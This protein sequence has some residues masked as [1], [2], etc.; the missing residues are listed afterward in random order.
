MADLYAPQTQFIGNQGSQ[1]P[2][3][4]A[5]ITGDVE[6]DRYLQS[7][8]E[9]EREAALQ[10]LTAPPTGDE[11]NRKVQQGY[12]P[13][14]DDFDAIESY[15]KN[16]EVNIAEGIGAGVE[17]VMG[18]LSRAVGAIADH[19]LDALS[20]SPAN[21]VEAFAQG[22]RNFYGMAAQSAD[23]TSTLFRF[24]NFLNGT[25]TKEERYNQYMEALAFNRES[26]AIMKGEKTLIMDK[27]LIT[28][29]VVQ[30]A[31]YIADPTLFIPFGNVASAGMRA[32][33]MGEKFMLASAKAAAIKNGLIG[34]T[35]KWG[36]GAPVEFLG[37]A[38]RNTIDY[39]IERGASAIA[40]TTGMA[41][42]EIAR[43]AKLSG[44]PLSAAS[45]AGHSIPYVGA[46][47]ETRVV[48]GAAGGFGEAISAVGETML[49][50]RQFGR[51][52]NSWA[53]EALENTPNL[54]G[55]A[56]GLLRVLDAVDPMFT[57]GAA[58][59]TGATHGALIGGT[60]GYLSG[61][62]EG[63]AHGLG[64]GIA[65]GAVGGTAGKVVADVTNGTLYER[66]AIQR[67]M[68]I[69]GLK[70]IDPDKAMA[71][72]ALVATAEKSG[73]RSYIA[74]ID[75]IIAGVDKVAPNSKFIIRSTADHVKWLQGEG[76]D[77][78]TG[79]L[80]ESHVKFKELGADRRVRGRA[81]G[82]LAQVGDQFAGKPD[83]FI[84]HLQTLPQDHSL[85]KAFFRLSGEQKQ[86]MLEAIKNHGDTEFLRNNGIEYAD[87]VD[88][89]NF[90][91]WLERNNEYF[92]PSNP[93]NNVAEI[94]KQ[95]ADI[96]KLN[97]SQAEKSKLID[98]LDARSK[99]IAEV[100]KEYQDWVGKADPKTQA[101][102]DAHQ[103]AIWKNRANRPVA[104]A[105]DP[106]KA[107]IKGK[108]LSEYYGD[109]NYAEMST[110]R[111]NDLFSVGDVAGARKLLGTFLKDNTLKDGTL[112]D[113]GRMLR[114]KLAAEG[115]FDKDGNL[116]PRR[117][118]A[119][120]DQPTRAMYLNS[121]GF[122][123][124]RDATGAIEVHIS[125]DNLSKDGMAHELFH[126]IFKESV[127]RPD[128]IDR[129]SKDL[130]GTFDK[131]GKLIKA[132]S[133]NRKELREFFRRYIDMTNDKSEDFVAEIA[134]LE[135]A[136]KEFETGSEAKTISPEA[137][138]T[139]HQ[140][141]EEFGA[142]YF[143]NWLRAQSPDFLFRGGK[144]EGVRGIMDSAK[145]GWLDF[146]E[147][148]FQSKDPRF[149]FGELAEGEIDGG[150]KTRDGKRIR[151]SSLDYFN[152]DFIRAT[153]DTNK[154]NFDINKLSAEG[155]A[156]Y[157]NSNGIRNTHR[158]DT[159]G[160]AVRLS[161]RE[162]AK[163]N[164][165]AGK[166]IYKI[167]KGINPNRAVDG[168]GN[169]I[170]RLN[171]AELDAIVKSGHANRAWANK[172]KMAYE[173]LDGKQS[174]VVE[175]GYFGKTEQI[176]DASYPRLYG[177]DV[178][179]KHRKAILLD[180]EMKIGQNGT[181]HALFHTLDKAVIEAR[182]DNLWKD[183]AVQDLWQGNRGSMEQDFF[184]Y[185]EN[186][187]KPDHDTSKIP[188]AEL[189]RDG[190]GGQ[191]RDV[192]HQMLGMAKGEGDTY[193]NKPIA[194][195][196]LGIRHSVTTFNNDGVSSFR[197][198]GMERYNYNHNNAFKLLS[199]NWKPS[200]MKSERT[201][202]GEIITHATGYKFIKNADGSV[203]AFTSAGL[204]IG[205]FDNIEQAAK[206]GEK[207][208]N[209]IYDNMRD[210]VAK[211]MEYQEKQAIRFKP[212]TKEQRL[213]A[214]ELGDVFALDEMKDFVGNRTLLRQTRDEH[215]YQRALESIND[216]EQL[217]ALA[218]KVAE[219]NGLVREEYNRQMREL[220]LQEQ[221]YEKGKD[222][223]LN[224]HNGKVA[225]LKKKYNVYD[226]F[227]DWRDANGHKDVPE[228][229]IDS[230]GKYAN[231]PEWKAS[232]R[233]KLSALYFDEQSSKMFKLEADPEHKA[234]MGEYA[235]WL[236]FNDTEARR[237][238]DVEDK[239]AD[240]KRKNHEAMHDPI[241]A[242][243][244]S[245][246]FEN[247][248]R[249]E[250]ADMLA[251][252]VE[253][254][255][256]QQD[257]SGLLEAMF[258][259]EYDDKI[260]TGKPFVAVT[261]HGTGNVE[262]MLSR[263]F[264]ADKLG[265]HYNIPSSRMGS[266]SAGSQGTSKAY[267][268]V[269]ATADRSPAG[270][271]QRLTGILNEEGYV[272]VNTEQ[273]KTARNFIDLYRGYL[274]DKGHPPSL[275]EAF[276]KAFLHTV[277]KDAVHLE[278]ESVPKEIRNA[279]MK[280]EQMDDK[281]L[282]TGVPKTEMQLRK[283]I[284]MDNPY[285]VVDPRSYDEHFI[286]PHMKRAME[287]G[288]DGIIFKRFADGGERDNVYVVFKDFMADNIKVI[289][290]SF[291]D[292]SVPRGKDDAGRVLKGGRELGLRF[293]PV[294]WTKDLYNDNGGFAKA[295]KEGRI[296][297]GKVEDLSDQTAVT[298]NPDN[299]LVGVIS[300][301][302]KEIFKGQG[303]V[304]YS[305]AN[306]ANAGLWASN[307]GAASK[308]ASYINN[309]I[310]LDI[311][312]N[313]MLPDGKVN[314]DYKPIVYL[315][316]AKSEA[317]KILTSE[318]GARGAMNVLEKMRDNGIIPE[319]VFRDSIIKALHFTEKETGSKI[320]INKTLAGD[321]LPARLH[322]L[323]FARDDSSF[324]GRGHFIDAFI[325]NIAEAYKFKDTI[326]KKNQ[327]KDKPQVI[328]DLKATFGDKYSK[329]FTKSG[330]IEAIS[331]LFTD[332][333][334]KGVQ[335]NE[336]Y[337]AI[338]IQSKVKIDNTSAHDAYSHALKTVDASDH[339]LVL[340]EKPRNVREVMNTA[341]GK[342]VPSKTQILDDKGN[343]AKSKKG[344]DIYKDFTAD[345]GFSQEGAKVVTYKS[346]AGMQDSTGMM[347]K[348]REELI[349]RAK[350]AGYKPTVY[351]HGTP[352]Q[353]TEFK[354]DVGRT[355]G[356]RENATAGYFFF[357]PNEGE[358]KGIH[359]SDAKGSTNV[360]Q[361]FLKYENPFNTSY[362]KTP[363]FNEQQKAKILDFYREH[364]QYA[365]SRDYL[366]DVVEGLIDRR[367]FA[368][369]FK[370]LTRQKRA[371]L[372]QSL[373]Y[374]SLID[375]GNHIV[376]FDPEQIK[377]AD[378]F[379]Y[380]DAG[381]EIPLSERF[382]KTKK[383]I[384]WKPLEEQGSSEFAPNS[385][386]ATS[387]MHQYFAGLRE[388]RSHQ[389]LMTPELDYLFSNIEGFTKASNDDIVRA[390]EKLGSRGQEVIDKLNSGK[391]TIREATQQALKIDEY[392]YLAKLKD[393]R[394]ERKNLY[395]KFLEVTGQKRKVSEEDSRRSNTGAEREHRN[396]SYKPVQ[397]EGG[398]DYYKP[399]KNIFESKD[400]LGLLVRQF[401]IQDKEG[402]D[403]YN[404]DPNALSYVQIGHGQSNLGGYQFKNVEIKGKTHQLKD[405]MYFIDDKGKFVSQ[406]MHPEATQTHSRYARENNLKT[407]MHPMG[408]NYADA[409]QGRVEMPIYEKGKLVRRGVASI[410]DFGYD[411]INSASDV[412]KAK[413]TI[414]ERLKISEED[415]DLY[416]FGAKD[417]VK[418]Q[419]GYGAKDN[420]PIKFKPTEAGEGGRV[421]DPK[422]KEFRTKFIGKWAEENPDRLKGYNI[423]F[424]D[425]GG[426]GGYRNPDAQ[427]VRIRL[428][429]NSKKGKTIDVGHITAQINHRGRTG[430][431]TA[432]ISTRIDEAYRG[433]K[434]SY[435]LY[436]EMAERLR[437]M[438]IKYVD[439]QIVNPEGI[440]IKVREK[441]IG[442]TLMI[443][444]DGSYAKARPISQAQGAK[445]I[446]R[447][448]AAGGE[449]DGID[450]VNKLDKN[451][452]YKPF[453]GDEGVI[454]DIDFDALIK[455]EEA[456]K[457][458]HAK[459]LAKQR[460][461]T[462]EE[463]SSSFVGR[464]AEDNPILTR[465]KKI[466]YSGSE[467]QKSLTLED[468]KT[469]EV[470]G[471]IHIQN[472]KSNQSSYIYISDVREAHQGRGYG[473][474]L[475]SEL[476]ERL[477][478]DGYTTLNGQIVDE[479]GRPFK[480]REKVID[481]ENKRIG[482]Q[483]SM[484]FGDKIYSPLYPEAHYK[485][486][487]GWR[488]WNSERTALGSVIKN[489]VGY[490]IIMS[491]DKFK[492]YNPQKTLIGIYTKEEEAKRRV[493]REEPKQ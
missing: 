418:A 82:F 392:T 75:G 291:D 78:T 470:I 441:I 219:K 249:Q 336:V 185:L 260:Q 139:L 245:G 300:A 5:G 48:A 294:E 357:T 369:S 14:L 318:N 159:T 307:K 440:P 421:Y 47:A 140:Y 478:A 455:A 328:A 387:L 62:E 30:A 415:F 363:K 170:G 34:G 157:I 463:M 458:K 433:N 487:E 403:I 4:Q 376:V 232:D 461:Y 39:G 350:Q 474:L 351:Y 38:V 419:R 231:N 10:R 484:I 19:P 233:T 226:S 264:S 457:K 417:E 12:N 304:F 459:A 488:D 72:E 349:K 424:I 317:G 218:E 149:R 110:A 227:A 375:K 147:R 97:I 229:I 194:E 202:S 337:G 57:Y 247:V 347:A 33:G 381:N 237:L 241:L 266:F 80:A 331:E 24:K 338:K 448:Q 379:T 400:D 314:P 238:I 156:H 87:R 329:G 270:R 284:R 462:E 135:S 114:N 345:F 412:K 8:P 103:Q 179:F 340:F 456:T 177:D 330:M 217:L 353:F 315:T 68:V 414:A 313:G 310:D 423:E 289:D 250:K 341:E 355:M 450:V 396:T 201:G 25:G 339:Q 422:S 333:A 428:Q 55:H 77:I 23:P 104:D 124:K 208:S 66:V 207:H 326:D 267:A 79:R 480:I 364:A 485:P 59:T 365:G 195:I 406:E 44:V 210:A 184:R 173:I 21:V 228:F 99:H 132:G 95:R 206:A 101:Q 303:G 109:I 352:K 420:L 175:F 367:N 246:L 7:L 37:G 279:W 165:T 309:A 164:A 257:Y 256:K 464:I 163:A 240:F 141:A 278:L 492:V 106:A 253:A 107:R 259:G 20:K 161:R 131:D 446:Q 373:G 67:K 344:N 283:V 258:A 200:E 251:G 190:K 216:P 354:S 359:G 469:G 305:T 61:G 382:D 444:A 36:V 181:F 437:S 445:I 138:A 11:I 342:P 146:W 183:S 465:G 162:A 180:V 306:D 144:L 224:V 472:R 215:I 154:G 467:T 372:L 408:W 447:R 89:K 148:T 56:K 427:N 15:H 155:Q 483:G 22:T 404:P 466:T 398:D 35:L 254:A 293:K 108:K 142:Y 287:A 397:Y 438:G 388:G 325:G 65:L 153:A 16:H 426:I 69:E 346:K 49:K 127:L 88:N 98:K 122:V 83:E 332:P 167:L 115:Y 269:A 386:T 429:D 491:G 402:L 389:E 86:V 479:L 489:T 362:G 451:S 143:Q 377:S 203:R 385:K 243:L 411:K 172:L 390:I 2:Q 335:Q 425:R 205:T 169:F 471:S 454:P 282:P 160:R 133:V 212:L 126:A 431:G 166:E 322:E 204:K 189:W 199:R 84:K 268:R 150:F 371:E 296:V 262:L 188:S 452:R 1:A 198:S 468:S 192:L 361:V 230:N 265:S 17:Q 274:T 432:T 252:L 261:T 312:R 334:L 277:D 255:A 32:V 436:S 168:D 394:D 178:S 244:N 299:S 58:I 209:S 193:I 311:K 413:G 130:I 28:P 223:W 374:D 320:D 370:Y 50:N 391:I 171:D 276:Y 236:D 395:K 263:L 221:A 111:V 323:F 136:I 348:P 225:A 285:V 125:L 222:D 308:L 90:K 63:M 70:T 476:A 43:T 145:N 401:V 473:T 40:A 292:A 409:L 60:L 120:D 54:S 27:D 18:D 113:R 393:V 211:D 45:F 213:R 298:I 112:N 477:R 174:N 74:H 118:T 439:G 214:V 116:R 81:L 493:Q 3:E 360:M 64:A 321:A 239:I 121:E 220:T 13:T 273:Y 6:V 301:D 92:D 176:T 343:P 234:L 91:E 481:Q 280:V 102:A 151:V 356:G 383:D 76:Y 26:E 302:G 490:A 290:T 449:Y 443:G 187:S 46:I 134:R 117:L 482:E 366:A 486:A 295:L 405:V 416:L 94:A 242:E 128:F 182:G 137:I 152:R 434:L 319:G 358:A 51:G 453:E 384:R 100:R 475:Y 31:S 316:L 123:L 442:E 368:E 281:T 119:S 85:R 407:A 288:H 73:D 378:D 71:F 460:Q 186:A 29:E 275:V 53:K 430:E 327:F 410:V 380:D 248:T 52:I 105:I 93:E 196:P 158:M 191:R 271:L 41:A 42:E 399:K 272:D 197:V 324:K 129:L 435:A 96:G 297:Y 9:E 235:Q 286:S